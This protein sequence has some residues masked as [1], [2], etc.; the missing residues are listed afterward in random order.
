MTIQEKVQW[1]IKQCN[2]K[3]T[4]VIYERNNK[5]VYAS[6]SVEWGSV[7]LKVN[8]DEAELTSEFN[9]LKEM[10]GNR[11]C[12]VYGYDAKQGV[13]I[14]ERIIPGTTLRCEEN[15]VIRVNQFLGLFSKIHKSIDHVYSP[16]TYLDWFKNADAFCM[17]HKPDEAIIN[18]MH[19]AYGM[20]EE[21]F[22][23]YNDRVLLHGDLHHDNII[24][25][26]EGIYCI[27]DPKG[28]IGPEIFDIPRYIL[29]EMDFVSA[30]ES[31]KHIIQVA[32][33]ISQ[34]TKYPFTDIIKLFF[35]EVMLGNVW[36]IEDGEKPDMHQ[37]KIATEL[38]N[39]L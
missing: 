12:K 4:I 37:I 28:V 36:C 10:H 8:T 20:G 23:K 21:L 32:E 3:N 2:L 24:L 5:A 13:L 6:E 25:N 39:D 14:E 30:E 29:N 7:I 35:M 18:N 11:C 27:I 16:I 38:V 26:D 34:E 33:M 1:A 17:S 19:K 15:M 9:M 22:Y 31:K